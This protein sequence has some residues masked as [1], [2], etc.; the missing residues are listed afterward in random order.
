[1]PEAESLLQHPV[2]L[3][4]KE[5]D[6]APGKG[7]EKPN[8]F[9]NHLIC[10]L[11]AG[12]GANKKRKIEENDNKQREAEAEE[13][14]GGLLDH[15][16]HNLVSPTAG[17]ATQKKTEVFESSNGGK[18]TGHEEGSV[19]EE[20]VGVSGGGLIKNAISNFFHRSDEAEEEANSI[21]KVEE[22]I[23]EENEEVKT[24]RGGG[25][26]DNIVSHLP[27]SLRG[28]YQFSFSS[29]VIILQ[30]LMS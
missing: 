12:E 5:E 19:S 6:E 29:F 27:T 4:S 9:L 28:M 17:G 26:I 15:I 1:M 16:I 22:N 2:N 30:N 14:R 25:I 13:K 21:Q 3:S 20:E 24:Q 8:G 10:N 7:E 23:V 18:R 11:I